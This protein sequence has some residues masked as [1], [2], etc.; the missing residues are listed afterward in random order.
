MTTTTALTNTAGRR[1]ETAS[2]AYT[3][4]QANVTELLS[5]LTAALEAHSGRATARPGDWGFSGDLSAVQCT[6]AR[7]LANLGDESG[8]RELGIDR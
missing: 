4:R 8:V 1:N 6:L 7:A 2:Q 3:V 5:R